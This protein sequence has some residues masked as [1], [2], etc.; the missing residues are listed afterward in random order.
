MTA[1]IAEK[2]TEVM[3]LAFQIDGHTFGS[4][5]EFIAFHE[6]T[7][8]VASVLKNGGDVIDRPTANLIRET[9]REV[10]VKKVV[11]EPISFSDILATAATLLGLGAAGYGIYKGVQYFRERNEERDVFGGAYMSIA[12]MGDNLGPMLTPNIHLG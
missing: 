9:V 1:T 11:G 2:A 7:A 5:E 6:H 4:E 10:E 3:P 12:Q 8:A